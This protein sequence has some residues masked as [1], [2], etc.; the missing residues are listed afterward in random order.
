MELN[1]WDRQRLAYLV[2]VV[3]VE[4]RCKNM[5]RIINR[6]I[7]VLTQA[8]INLPETRTLIIS[9]IETPI[10]LYIIPKVHWHVRIDE[11]AQEQHE[12]G[13]RNV[14]FSCHSVTHVVCCS[15]GRFRRPQVVRQEVVAFD[16]TALQGRVR[17]VWRRAGGGDEAEVRA[18]WEARVGEGM[19]LEGFG[20][21]WKQVGSLCISKCI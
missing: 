5:R 4:H 7:G 6:N 11:I 9:A 3:R 16:A 17:E 1:N 21:I 10:R 15:G 19:K 14:R 13:R 20:R 8:F 12:L 2:V 18:C